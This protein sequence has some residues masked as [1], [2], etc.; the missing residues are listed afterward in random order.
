ML[1]ND[2][3]H[4]LNVLLLS[5]IDFSSHTQMAHWNVR[6]NDFNSLHQFFGQLYSEISLEVDIIA[7]KLRQN[8]FLVNTNSTVVTEFSKLVEFVQTSDSKILLNSLLIDL[9][10]LSEIAND[11]SATQEIKDDFGLSNYLGG[12]K[13]KL[14]KLT[15]LTDS[16]LE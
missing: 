12:L 2:T 10:I 4:K 14:D 6:G 5:I 9:M 1:S 3:K 13:E 16:N 7:E 8:K 11:L 15:W